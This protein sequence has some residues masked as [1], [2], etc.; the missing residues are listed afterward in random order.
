[1]SHQSVQNLALSQVPNLQSAIVGCGQ[2]IGPLRMK[3]DGINEIIMCI[4]VLKESVR[5]VVEDFNLLIRAARSNA[6]TIWMKLYI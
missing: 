5:P 4:I 3:G 2:Q 6:G 1:M